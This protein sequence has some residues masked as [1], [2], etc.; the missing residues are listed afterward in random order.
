MARRNSLQEK[1]EN[2]I[3]ESEDTVFLTRDFRD[4]GGERQV[5]RALRNT[6]TAGKLI[7]IGY[8]SYA[9]AEISP[10]TQQPMLA[11]DGFST[12]ARRILDKLRVVWEPASAEKAYNSGQST[13]VPMT[14]MVHLKSRCSRKLR[15]KNME[16][17]FE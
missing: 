14:A 2:R 12:I 6:V 7:R 13:Q 15:Y 8:G 17:L 16:L 3:A 1:I 11:G 9:K 4:L 5:L 10:L